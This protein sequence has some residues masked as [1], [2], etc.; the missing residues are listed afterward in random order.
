MES[1]TADLEKVRVKIFVGI[2]IHDSKVYTVTSDGH[3][4]IFDK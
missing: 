1:K 4:Y 3:V 2:A